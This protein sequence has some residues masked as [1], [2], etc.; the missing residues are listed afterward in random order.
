MKTK[1]ELLAFFITFS[2]I[3]AFNV[4]F[5][6]GATVSGTVTN[7]A[8][9]A[10]E[11]FGVTLY[12]STYNGCGQSQSYTTQ[13]NADGEYTISDVPTG[14]FYVKTNSFN[15]SF[16]KEFWA[17]GES[18]PDCNAAQSF[19]IASSGQ[20]ETGKDF[21]LEQGATISG[22][23]ID[24]NGQPIANISVSANLVDNPCHS[25]TSGNGFV[26][27]DN[28]GH[29][30]LTGLAVG[31]YYIG[32]SNWT[33]YVEEKWA[34]GASVQDCSSADP[35]N[36]TTAG[37][38]V[39][40]K[41][42]QLELGATISGTVV[43]DVGQPIANLQIEL[44]DAACGY[45]WKGSASTDTNGVYTVT[46]LPTGTYYIKNS[47]WNSAY[48][49]EWWA[50]GASVQD[51]NSADPVN[52]NTSGQNVTGKDFQLEVGASISGTVV[53]DAGQPIPDL[54]IELYDAACGYNQKGSAFTDTNGVYT[55]AGLPTGTYYIKNSTWNSA[56]ISEWW[57][58]GASVQDC[59]SAEPVNI[60]TAGQ[61]VTGKDFQLELGATVSGTVTDE[62]GQPIANLQVYLYDAACGY[63]WKGYASTDTNGVYTITGLPTGTYYIQT[64]HWYSAYISEWWAD[65]ASVQD[66]SSAEPVNINTAGQTVGGKDFQLELGATIS[67]TVVDDAGQPIANLQVNLYDAACGSN[68]QGSSS[69]DANG[70]YTIRGLLPG[71]YYV[72]VSTWSMGYLTEWWAAGASVQG[73]NNAEP[74]TVDTAGQII[75]SKDFQLELGATV[76]GRV[77]DSAGTPIANLEVYA[78]ER[79]IDCSSGGMGGIP[80]SASTN[81]DGYYTI[82][83]LPIGRY[84]LQSNAYQTDYIQ[85]WWSNSG[86]VQDQSLA[87]DINITANGQTETNKNFQLEIGVS[88]S[89][90]LTKTGGEPVSGYSIYAVKGDTAC[91]N[92]F[93]VNGEIDSEGN[94][95]VRGLAPGNYFVRTAA[96]WNDTSNYSDEW[97]STSGNAYSCNDAE[98]I[99]VAAISI[100]GKNIQLDPGASISG[101]I[102]NSSA[103][104]LS[105]ITVHVSNTDDPCGDQSF[106]SDVYKSVTPSSTG[107]YTITGLPAGNYYLHA[108]A[109]NS[110]YVEEWYADA[111]NTK[112]CSSA[113]FISVQDQ[114]VI[115][116]KDFELD[117]GGTISGTIYEADGVTTITSGIRV[118]IYSSDPCS[119]SAWTYE[120]F[121]SFCTGKYTTPALEPGNYYIS[122]YSYNNDY[123]NEWWASPDSISSCASA[124]Q[125][126]V[127]AGMDTPD[128][129]FQLNQR[130]LNMNPIFMLLLKEGD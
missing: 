30:T 5:V 82:I 89:G 53:D 72:E 74:V 64:D 46:G 76:S 115:N 101:T 16:T 20:T 26:S 102:S 21:Q 75:N 2:F 58:D 103:E 59:N 60:N 49:S 130:H 35:V 109:W 6:L 116:N 122:T 114:E 31:T 36:V 1:K 27:S 65:G 23:V 43:D 78:G 87:T 67:G 19:Q 10:I 48:I 51:C 118:R 117:Q 25:N 99:P 110:E 90:V 9:T 70:V 68:G 34:D 11:N 14:T 111:G 4:T 124:Q 15:T 129:N 112:D 77:I 28:D 127:S 80:H 50:D 98:S 42:F 38:D 66:C 69:T 62:A 47:T 44:Y 100:T 121:S 54:Q 92:I 123:S 63:S 95:I 24:D 125:I 39:Q 17:A 55:I 107:N 18:V 3:I 94:F 73:C 84:V 104:P 106:Y 97:W 128:K 93:S 96:S 45:N 105:D 108:Y 81:S 33:G 61:N 7:S 37:E 29:Y 41:D 88:I 85:E 8:G 52:I 56:Y 57:A 40:G 126:T 119:T 113:D 71:S 86:S 91:S 32:T 12:T 120:G 83:G 13:T 79:F 22:T